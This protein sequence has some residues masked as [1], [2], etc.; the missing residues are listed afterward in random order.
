MDRSCGFYLDATN[1]SSNF[2]NYSNSE[3]RHTCSASCDT[4]FG[5][6]DTLYK[7]EDSNP[8]GDTLFVSTDCETNERLDYRSQDARYDLDF[9]DSLLDVRADLRN[10]T[11]DEELSIASKGPFA[12]ETCYRG[13]LCSYKQG[14][15]GGDTAFAPYNSCN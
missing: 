15:F 8:G 9:P 1:S 2:G 14:M 13:C 10:Y 4:V 6:T 3:S 5:C 11:L 7:D 12:D